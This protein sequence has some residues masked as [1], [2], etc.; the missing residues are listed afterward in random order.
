LHELVS[1]ILVPNLKVI[2]SVEQ[3][4]D[5][6]LTFLNFTIKLITEPLQFFLFLGG[7]DH[8]VSLAMLASIRFSAA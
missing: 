8:I 5:F 1:V 6:F 2:K 4:F 3:S 7:L